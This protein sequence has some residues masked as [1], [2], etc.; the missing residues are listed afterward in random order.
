LRKIK[1]AFC[2]DIKRRLKFL[3]FSGSRV[4]SAEVV[5]LN[6]GGQVKRST[7]SYLHIYFW[8]MP[9]LAEKAVRSATLLHAEV[10]LVAVIY[11][12]VKWRGGRWEG[13]GRDGLPHRYHMK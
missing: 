1:I 6:P 11:R 8:R 4:Y 10:A 13:T 7:F 2:F 5:A 3:N 12:L 9:F